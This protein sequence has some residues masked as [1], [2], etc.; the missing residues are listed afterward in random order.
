MRTIYKKLILLFPV[1]IIAFHFRIVKNDIMQYLLVELAE[2]E[3]HLDKFNLKIQ[4]ATTIFMET[5][6]S[7]S[8]LSPKMQELCLTQKQSHRALSFIRSCSI[9]PGHGNVGLMWC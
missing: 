8:L 2:K 5:I 4:I 6:V 9:A 3:T 1:E 7:S